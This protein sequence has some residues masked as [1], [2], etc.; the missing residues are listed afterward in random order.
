MKETSHSGIRLYTLD[1]LVV[2]GTGCGWIVLDRCNLVD[3]I[4]RIVLPCRDLWRVVTGLPNH[5]CPIVDVD[6]H[7]IPI[8]R[9]SLH[10]KIPCRIFEYTA[11]MP[12][13]LRFRPPRSDL[14]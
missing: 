10:F 14:C 8:E 2:L 1:K 4:G 13:A 9:T 5:Q 3:E 6:V 7:Q 12:S 11:K